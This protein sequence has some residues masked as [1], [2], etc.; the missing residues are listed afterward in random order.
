MKQTEQQL[1]KLNLACGERTYSDYI[2]IDKFHKT[3]DIIMDLENYPWDIDSNYAEEILAQHFLEHVADI[4][5]F[6]KEIFRV[7]KPNGI[8]HIF[9]PHY[10]YGFAHPFHVRGFSLGFMNFIDHYVPEVDFEL[11]EPV[12]LN[13]TRSSNF[14]LRCLKYPINF[15][16]NLHPQFCERIWCYWVG[17]FEEMEFKVKSF[18]KI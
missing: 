10:S 4:N 3:A 9:V 11:I 5:S 8:L 2:N 18:K 17:G 15:F 16:A 7:L 14:V 12:K 6:L 13:Y 1:I